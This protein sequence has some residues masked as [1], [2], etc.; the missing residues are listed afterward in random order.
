MLPG[1]KILTHGVL[2]VR[3]LA[4]DLS[5][6]LLLTV[7]N[8][9]DLLKDIRLVFTQQVS[10]RIR[11]AYS[12]CAPL[13]CWV[14]W[15]SV[16]SVDGL[17]SSGSRVQCWHTGKLITGH[18]QRLGLFSIL[19]PKGPLQ[20]R[21]FLRFLSTCVDPVS[22][23]WIRL[24]G[25]AHPI[26]PNI[27]LAR[28]PVQV[29]LDIFANAPEIDVRSLSICVS[30]EVVDSRCWEPVTVVKQ[31]RWEVAS[32]CGV[33]TLSSWRG[34]FCIQATQGF[35]SKLSILVGTLTP[36]TKERWASCV[37]DQSRACW[38][39]LPLFIHITRVS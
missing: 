30:V 28:V 32:W 33:S 17:E 6:I 26:G 24:I 22:M 13:C 19:G 12:A 21:T 11:S 2:D 34:V 4:I 14:D 16:V 18:G 15:T 23:R 27:L 7:R 1:T 39:T 35:V 10:K 8:T 31:R 3:K 20:L 5:L 25:Q 36:S 38:I 29:F 9:C 37:F